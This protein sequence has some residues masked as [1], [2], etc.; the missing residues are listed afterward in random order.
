RFDSEELIAVVVDFGTN[1]LARLQAHCDQLEVVAGVE[2]SAEVGVVGSDALDVVD[3][4]LHCVRS[5]A[6]LLTE[7]P[8][9]N[10]VPRHL[11]SRTD[12]THVSGSGA[13]KEAL[14][15][16]LSQKLSV[17]SAVDFAQEP[18]PETPNLLRP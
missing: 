1:L 7:A 3:V 18:L 2:H 6:G 10:E 12:G 11:H 8:R 9:S 14:V 4:A 16:P 5:P 13:K 17:Q 15:G